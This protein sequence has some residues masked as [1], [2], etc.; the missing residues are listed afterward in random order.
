[1]IRTS[2]LILLFIIYQ[3][4]FGQGAIIKGFTKDCELNEKHEKITVK[5]SGTNIHASSNKYG[6]FEFRNLIPGKYILETTLWEPENKSFDTIGVISENQVVV[7][8]ICLN[9]PWQKLET[10]PEIE[11]YHAKLKDVSREQEILELKIES[12]NFQSDEDLIVSTY[13]TNKSDFPIYLWKNTN[14]MQQFDVI[15]LNSKGD[16][17]PHICFNC[18]DICFGWNNDPS[19]MLILESKS[20]TQVITFTVSP[21]YWKNLP[22]DDYTIKIEYL[23]NCPRKIGRGS[24]QEFMDMHT[25]ALRGRYIS[26]DSFKFKY[27]AIKSQDK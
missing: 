22:E 11:D 5:I 20:K 14:C 8:D 7:H 15:V 12:L 3:S 4:L 21:L 17:I 2:P 25:K 23:Y 9:T 18:K 19:T 26:K 6:E 27:T 13:L 24:S 1:M 10:K 16:T